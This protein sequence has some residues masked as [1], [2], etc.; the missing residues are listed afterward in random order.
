MRPL[1]IALLQIAP[2]GGWERIWKRESVPVGKRQKMGADIALFPEMWSN[3]YN[4]YGPARR[5][6][7]R[8]RLFPPAAAF[9]RSFQR[10]AGEL[11]MAIGVTLLEEYARRPAQ[12]ACSF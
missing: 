4:I 6:S 10:L 12:Y 5:R 3:G 2:C 8:L 1:K 9:V 11:E 7:G